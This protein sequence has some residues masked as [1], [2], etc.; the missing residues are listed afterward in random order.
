MV[1]LA[2]A[3][4]FLRAAGF[5]TRCCKLPSG[6]FAGM[7]FD[8]ASSVLNANFD[9]QIEHFVIHSL[10]LPFLAPLH[11]LAPHHRCQIEPPKSVPLPWY[12]LEAARYEHICAER[13]HRSWQCVV[14]EG[15]IFAS[16]HG[17]PFLHS[18]SHSHSDE[19][20]SS[21]DER[22]ERID[23]MDSPAK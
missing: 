20:A 21:A 5:G 13:C 9:V 12:E 15:N 22:Q 18:H 3:Q 4:R 19:Q 17:Y 16:D 11:A 7:A 23:F 14:E 1:W 10:C 8:F 2:C 6:P